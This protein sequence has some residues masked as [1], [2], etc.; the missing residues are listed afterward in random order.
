M[1]RERAV[2]LVLRLGPDC[3]R[4]FGV[5][6]FR[7]NGSIVEIG[8]RSWWISC[9]VLL[10]L[11]CLLAMRTGDRRYRGRQGRAQDLGGWYLKCQVV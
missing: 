5:A 6:C 2:W 1:E 11:A 7:I 4:R 9:F 8:S 3:S 10:L